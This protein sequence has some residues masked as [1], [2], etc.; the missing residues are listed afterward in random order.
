M[1]RQKEFNESDALEQAMLA[2]WQHGYG[3]TGIQY[4]VETTGV[5]RASLYGTFGNKQHLFLSALRRYTEHCVSDLRT[6]LESGSGAGDGIRRMLQH[7]LEITLNSERG[8][9]LYNTALEVSAHDRDIQ[10]AVEE[11]MGQIESLVTQWVRKAQAAGEADP[12]VDPVVL[13]RTLMAA[14]QGIAVRGSGGCSREVL[15]SI[16]DGAML[17]LRPPRAN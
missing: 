3:G 15:E 12:V 13:G 14:M 16:R 17:G 1:A 9:L 8:C 11:G 10:R 7:F 6:A 4:L 2:F 5:N